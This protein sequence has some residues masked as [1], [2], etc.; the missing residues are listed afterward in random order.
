M[1]I[2]YIFLPIGFLLLALQYVALLA[3]SRAKSPILPGEDSSLEKPPE[4]E[5]QI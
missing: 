2:P 3:A 4:V 5:Q 1:V